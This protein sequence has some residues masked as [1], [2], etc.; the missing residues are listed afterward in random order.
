LGFVDGPAIIIHQPWRQWP[1]VAIDQ[2]DRTRRSV[3][4]YTTNGQ[5]GRQGGESFS[6]GRRDGSPPFFGV[7]FVP[8]SDPVAGQF[9]RPNSQSLATTGDNNGTGTLS[10]EIQSKAST[11]PGFL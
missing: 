3:N 7:L 2:Q 10:S 6:T 11:V 5:A 9:V 8:G 1:A 4:R